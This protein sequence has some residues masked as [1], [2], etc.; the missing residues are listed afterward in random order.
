LI[1]IKKKDKNSWD[2]KK[3]KEKGTID[4]DWVV[5]YIGIYELCLAWRCDGFF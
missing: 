4:Q 2:K 5:F 3:E 1:G